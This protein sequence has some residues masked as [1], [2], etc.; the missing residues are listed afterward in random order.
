MANDDFPED[1]AIRVRGVGK[2][3]RLGV[4]DRG[5]FRDELLYRILRLR[6]RDPRASMGRIGDRET[7]APGLFDALDGISFDVRRGET[8]GLVGRT[9][10]GKSTMLKILARITT[11]TRGVALIRGRVG[12]MLEVGTGF[13]PELTGRE[14]VYLNGS[15]L[16]MSKK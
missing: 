13:H 6:G 15:I 16:G 2:T 11:P 14:N 8:V 7:A 9:G 5:T 4:I 3:Y 10:A 1:L 12:S